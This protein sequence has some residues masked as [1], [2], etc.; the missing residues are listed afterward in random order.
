MKVLIT[1]RCANELCKIE[2]E[3]KDKRRVHCSTKCGRE[4]VKQYRKTEKSKKI[5][6][7][8][9]KKYRQRKKLEK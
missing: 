7:E 4:A 8:Y 3:T 1:K 9:H 2:F 5:C 6:K